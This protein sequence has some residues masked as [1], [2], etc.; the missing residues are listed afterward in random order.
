MSIAPGRV[1]S[2]T[3]FSKLQCWEAAIC[4][5][6]DSIPAW[7]SAVFGSISD[8]LVFLVWCKC[9]NIVVW[10]FQ[11][12][13][14]IFLGCF[15]LQVF[16]FTLFHSVSFLVCRLPF[17]LDYL[18]VSVT[19]SSIFES[20]VHM[21]LV[22]A[23]TLQSKRHFCT[24]FVT[25]LHTSST[26]KRSHIWNLLGFYILPQLLMKVHTKKFT[27]EIWSC[28][29]LVLIFPPEICLRILADQS[30]DKL[31]AVVLDSSC[32]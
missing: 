12:G 20:L 1:W 23:C 30:G 11:F 13:G 28:E 21:W 5:H 22:S 19:P 26:W 9:W 10:V 8:F 18:S 3:E 31:C 15:L 32:R 27:A 16:F 4:C 29:N 17:L 24:I 6:L 25:I 14:F 7:F 2:W